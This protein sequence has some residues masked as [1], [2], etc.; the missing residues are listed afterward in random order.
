MP[1]KAES[2]WDHS[3]KLTVFPQDLEA[4]YSDILKQYESAY[5][6]AED[7]KSRGLDPNEIVESKTV[8]DLADRVN[9]MLG[10]AQFEGLAERLRH[11]L[12]TT[13]K[14]KATLAIAEE[15]ALGKFGAMSKDQALQ[16]AVRTGLAVI[17]DGVTVAP[18]QG[19]S[20]V[21]IKKN[22]DNSDYASIS[23]AGP[24]RSAGGTEAAFSVLIT[25]VVAKKLGLSPYRAREEEIARYIEELRVYEREVGNFQYRVSDSDVRVALSNLPVEIDGVETDPFE[26][27]V[28]RNLKRVATDRVRGGA[29][30]VLND[31]VIGRAHKL[32]KILKELQLSGWDWLPE[33]K[34]GKQQSSSDTEKVGAHFEEII[35]GRPVISSPGTRGGLRIRYGRAMNTG[36]STVGIHPAIPTLLDDCVVVGTQVKVDAPGKAATIAFVDSI[37][38]PTIRLKDGSVRK[39]NSLAEAEQYH[40]SLEV[41]MDMGD[42][43]ISYGDFLENNKTLGPSPY[44][45]EWWLQD[46]ARE[47]QKMQEF[48]DIDDERVQAIV[49]GTLPSATEALAISRRL[50]IPLHPSFTPRFDRILP[51]DVMEL[52]GATTRSAARHIEVNITSHHTEQ[53]L[54]HLLVPYTR[55]KDSALIVGEWATIFEALLAVDATPDLKEPLAQDSDHTVELVNH[56]SGVRLGRQTTSTVGMRVGRPEKAMLR[57]MKPPVH[58]LF[59]V[60]AAG[61]N[62]RDLLAAAKHG[63]MRVDMVNIICPSCGKRRLSSRCEECGEATIRFLS[64]PRCSQIINA[65]EGQVCPRCRVEGVTHSFYNLDVKA[66]VDALQRKIGDSAR[67]PIKGVRGL[68][69]SSKYAEPIE[70]GALRSKHEIYVY[71]DGTARVDV[72]NA[73]LTHFRPDNIHTQVQMLHSLGYDVDKDGNPLLQPDQVVA[74]KP[75]DI[76]V[77]E[78]T[79]RDLLRV[80]SFV[81]DELENVY[82]LPRF[83]NARTIDDLRGKVVVGLAPHTSVGVAGR[84]VGFSNAQVCFANPCWHSAKRRDCDGDGDSVLLLLDIFLNFS[85]EYIPT[86]IGGLMD[87]PLLIQPI[88]LPAEVDDQAHNF[89]VAWK[90]PTTFYEATNF[91]PNASKAAPLIETIR[92][93]VNKP[94]QFYNYGFTHSTSSITIKSPRSAYS[95]LTTL[96]DKIAKQVEVAEKIQAVSAKQVVES[97]IKTHL[98]RDIMGNMKKYSTQSFKCRGCSRTLRRPTVSARCEV[99]GGELRETLTRGSVE[100]Y[101]A[102]ARRLAHDHD[103]DP[104]I[105]ERLDLLVREMDQLFPAREKSTQSELG[106]FAAPAHSQ[107]KLVLDSEV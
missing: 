10:L 81:D 33:L 40:D 35:S 104:Y 77:P 29:L 44:V 16:Y 85:V 26:V 51:S 61:G 27:V 65:E 91:S 39:V 2:A 93:R 21:L 55:T 13:T 98:I 94:T 54:Q 22:D 84:I 34:G 37:E 74:L 19:I 97:I 53:I 90:Y 25:D 86:Q 76:V 83:Y 12:H 5:N 32:S 7:A 30:R 59:P 88:I 28:H 100:K 71:K 41:I 50:G 56:I 42:A 17:T 67:G 70:K 18:I 103:V 6:M 45:T 23:Y 20:T 36:L 52:R 89:D 60:G 43:L 46:F 4:Y 92:D 75:Q 72:T 73:P 14:E 78:D 102:I 96:A 82:G 49:N 99:C 58:V 62:T 64:C 31:G 95:T 57:H 47:A 24:M 63:S 80:A 105:K 79:A 1:F 101:L 9:E 8:F 66:V 107:T 11:L 87:T 68:S 69:S 106:D 48:D 38:G 15:I 3:R